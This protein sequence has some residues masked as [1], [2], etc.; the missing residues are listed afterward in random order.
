VNFAFDRGNV[1]SITEVSGVVEDVL[2]GSA[3]VRSSWP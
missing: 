1:T 2:A 3:F